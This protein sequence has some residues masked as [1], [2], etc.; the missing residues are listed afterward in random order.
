MNLTPNAQALL[1]FGGILWGFMV[2]E[3][4]SAILEE[5]RKRGNDL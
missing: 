5:L 3:R 4:L 1:L 2:V